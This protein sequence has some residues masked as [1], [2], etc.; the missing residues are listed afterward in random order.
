MI[1]YLLDGIEYKP[2]NHLYAVSR[3]GKFLR[4]GVPINPKQRPD[5]YLH[6]GR[7]QL[8]H[9]LVA[10]VWCERPDGANHVHHINHI[11]TD[12]RKENLQWVTPKQHFG[13]LHADTHGRHTMSES[14]RQ[15]L[16]TLRLG[17]KTSEATKQ[18]QREAS[19]R[20]GCR[21]PAPMLGRKLSKETIAKMRENSPNANACKVNGVAYQS[22]NQAGDA[23]GI[24]PHTLRKR[25]LSKNFPEYQLET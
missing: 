16:R 9:R 13:E 2:F 10:A 4:K 12:N 1:S 21:P 18:K 22:F 25:C 24:K 23:L 3:C 8:A 20:L 7:Q 15:K 11:K 19:L 17:S 5:G 14:G 6:I